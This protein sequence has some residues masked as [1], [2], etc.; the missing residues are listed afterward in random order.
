VSPKVPC[1]LHA[2]TRKQGH[3]IKALGTRGRNVQWQLCEFGTGK[4]KAGQARGGCN[5]LMGKGG[6]LV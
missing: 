4:S 2:G 1:R 3:G 6:G 5:V